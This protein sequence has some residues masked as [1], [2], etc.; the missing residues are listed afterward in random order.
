ML[1]L[2]AFLALVGFAHCATQGMTIRSKWSGGFAGTFTLVPTSTVHGWTAHLACDS[3]ID[4]LE[5]WTADIVSKSADKTEYVLRNKPYDADINAGSSLNVDIVGR[6]PG[7]DTPPNCRVFIEGQGGD[8]GGG[9]QTPAPTSPPATQPPSGGSGSHTTHGSSHPETVTS[10]ASCG[11]AKS[12]KYNYGQALGLSI[13]FYDAQRS[14]KMPANNPIPWRHDSAMNDHG[15]GGVDLTGGWYDAGDHVKFNLPMASSAHIL[16][17]GL[18]RWKDGYESA[19][20]L[21]NMY[22]MLRTP[23]DYF[24]KCWRPSSQEYYAQVGNGGTDHAFWGRPEDMRM[25]RPAYKCTASNGG[26]SDVEGI[27]AAALAVGSI[28]FKSKDPSYSQRLLSSAKSLYQFAS[29]HKGIYNKGPISDA[30]SYYGSTGYKDELCV[31]AMEL[32][33]ATK[34]PKYLADAKANFEGTETAWALSW[35]DEHVFCQLL[36]YEETKEAKYKSLVDSFVKSYMPGGSV[37]QTPCGLAWRDQW[38]SLRY[39]G[40]AAFVALAAAEDGIGGDQFKSWALSQINYILGDNNHHISYEIGY[41]SNYPRQP[42]HRGSSCPNPP[43][44]CSWN[45]FNNPGPSPQLLKGALVGGPGRGDEY[46]D[47]RKDYTKNEVTCDY[48]AGFQS[49]LAALTSMAKRGCLPD[50]PPAKYGTPQPL[51]LRNE[52]NTGIDGYFIVKPSLLGKGW[53]ATISCDRDIGQLEIWSA[54][55]VTATSGNSV[56]TVR[57]EE[58]FPDGSTKPPQEVE[59]VIRMPSENNNPHCTVDTAPALDI[60]TTAVPGYTFSSSETMA[61]F[62]YSEALSLSIL[63]FDTQRSG[64]LPANNPISWRNDS[65]VDDHGDKGEDLSGGWYDAGDH[66]KFNLPMA[67]SAH[68]LS[69]G[70]ERWKDAYRSTGHLEMMYDMLKWPLDYFLKCWNPN[71]QEYYAQI[72][73]GKEDHRYWGR[74]EDMSKFRPMWRPAYKCTINDTCSDVAG[75]TAAA[76]ASGAIVFKDRN[77]TYSHKLLSAA[78]S[79]YEFAKRKQGMYGTTAVQDANKYYGSHSYRDELCTAAMELFKATQNSSY[80]T[81]AMSFFDSGMRSWAFSWDDKN[82]QCAL[83]LYKAVGDRRFS[84]HVTDFLRSFMPGGGVRQTPCGLAWRTGDGPLRYTA[85]AALVALMAAD[86]GIGGDDYKIWAM[87][88]INYMLG[89]NKQNMSYQIGYGEN[90]PQKPYHRASSC[91]DPPSSPC[92]W[93]NINNPGPSPHILKGALVGGPDENDVYTDND[94][95]CDFNAGFQS[96][97]AGLIHLQNKGLMPSLSDPMLMQKIKNCVS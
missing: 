83:M 59:V 16:G 89:D 31:A 54:S 86:E 44:G 93:D 72:G 7:R 63:F 19:N 96:A 82:V 34:E 74:P 71:T 67:S 57:N 25:S 48:N 22:D 88:Q 24:M 85:N 1:R 92:G 66:V 46:A 58:L 97:L 6:T 64:I 69:W 32:Y 40:N 10:G 28:A 29:T 33:K 3:A 90:Y 52:W 37:A 45:D 91:P 73:N 49:A 8:S 39:A 84:T 50:S 55:V 80:L 51:H 14:G 17:Y 15:D 26:C 70:L 41:G 95:A 62:N 76:M 20:Q 78:K 53:E 11:S 47:S 43:A 13:L 12:T 60:R 27:T 56:F 38:G 21:Q 18:S 79:L 94:V 2:W 77:V 35:D 4:S 36:L 61:G 81:D 9:S 23:L 68:F 75:E 65:A 5:I 30:S 87:K 42:H